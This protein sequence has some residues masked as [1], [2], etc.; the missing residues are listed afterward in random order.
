MLAQAQNTDL[1]PM[2]APS[3]DHCTAPSPVWTRMKYRDRTVCSLS[4][5][6]LLRDAE[7]KLELDK[8]DLNPVVCRCE[9]APAP[10]EASGVHCRECR[11]MFSAQ[12][13]LWLTTEETS[14]GR[15]ARIRLG[16]EKVIVKIFSRHG[17]IPHAV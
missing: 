3:C 16:Y 11:R 13:R 6:T 14:N 5:A 1:I 8:M 12:V 7:R 2:S 9:G 4:C 10:L 17:R 15:F